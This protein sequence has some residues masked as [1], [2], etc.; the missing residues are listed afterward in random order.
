MALKLKKKT[1]TK[2]AAPVEVKKTK[3]V[4]K[5]EVVEKPKKAAAI[6]LH[7]F[8]CGQ[9][10]ALKKEGHYV[11][12]LVSGRKVRHGFCKECGTA[13]A[14]M[15]G[16][17]VPVDR[18]QT[19]AEAKVKKAQKEVKKRTKIETLTKSNKTKSLKKKSKK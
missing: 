16:K 17:D 7:C 15:V 3:K 14:G 2:A 9:K 1:T 10:V 8:K 5:A 19:V 12:Q 6:E 13:V 11:E 4:T 18:V